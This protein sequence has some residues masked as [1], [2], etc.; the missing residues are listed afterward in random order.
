M[1]NWRLMNSHMYW[2]FS[3]HTIALTPT[4][5][6]DPFSVLPCLALYLETICCKRFHLN[7]FAPWLLIGMDQWEAP[8]RDQR[9]SGKKWWYFFLALYFPVVFL[10]VAL[11]CRDNSSHRVWLHWFWPLPLLPW[12]YNSFHQLPLSGSFSI[13]THHS[14]G[15]PFI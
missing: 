13:F 5:A 15:N 10:A 7:L 1:Y 4:V 2:F 14:V 6:T 3:V 9:M 12:K 11:P 8:A